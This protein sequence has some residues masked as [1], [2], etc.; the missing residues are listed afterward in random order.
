MKLGVIET[1]GSSVTS[2]VLDQILRFVPQ[3]LVKCTKWPNY[4]GSRLSHSS[5]QTVS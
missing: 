3:P 5:T 4:P 2:T 1:N